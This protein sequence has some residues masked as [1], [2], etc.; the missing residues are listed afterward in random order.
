MLK[1]W[2]M[3]IRSHEILREDPSGRCVSDGPI[4]FSSPVYHVYKAPRIDKNCYLEVTLSHLKSTF[5]LKS[6]VKKEKF[7]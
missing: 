7:M 4:E 5:F 1:V 6:F 3:A 2:S